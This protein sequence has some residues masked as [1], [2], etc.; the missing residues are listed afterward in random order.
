MKSRFSKIISLALVIVMLVQLTPMNIFA[1]N[2]SATD[3][4]GK[5]NGTTI[6][7]KKLINKSPNGLKTV[8]LSLNISPITVPNIIEPSNIKDDL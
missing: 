3:T 4:A 5:I 7:S 6:T 1:A 2:I 8:A